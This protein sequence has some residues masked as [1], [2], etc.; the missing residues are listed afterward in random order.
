MSVDRRNRSQHDL[1]FRRFHQTEK[2][3]GRA[4]R[5]VAADN[6]RAVILNDFRDAINELKRANDVQFKR[7]AQVQADLDVIKQAWNRMKMLV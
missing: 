3:S 5:T 4:A 6:E 7:V 2:Q 1:A